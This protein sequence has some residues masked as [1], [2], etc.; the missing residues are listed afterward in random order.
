MIFLLACMADLLEQEEGFYFES[1]PWP[2]LS[3]KGEKP[4]LKDSLDRLP[5]LTHDRLGTNQPGNA[6]AAE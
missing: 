6:S 4:G 2:G 3:E 5:L 1:Q